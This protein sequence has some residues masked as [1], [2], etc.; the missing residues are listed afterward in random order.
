M[1]KAIF[2]V[3]P[4]SSGTRMMT[5]FFI[6]AGY[7]GEHGHAQP[8]DRLEFRKYPDNIVFRQ[9]MPHGSEWADIVG[10]IQGMQMA[11]YTPHGIVT[12]RDPRYMALSQVQAGHSANTDQA[13]K[14]I[15]KAILHIDTAFDELGW[16]P[17]LIIYDK[18]VELPTYQKAIHGLHSQLAYDPMEFSNANQKYARSDLRGLNDKKLKKIAETLGK[19]KAFRG[20]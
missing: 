9:S 19:A 20:A 8:W 5:E 13:L 1:R 10:I 7:E 18:F 17:T 16:R 12:W 3:G 11:N 6:R 15:K 2:V 14:K 4:E